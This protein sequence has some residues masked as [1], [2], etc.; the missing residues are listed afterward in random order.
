MREK[1]S[2]VIDVGMTQGEG[3]QPSWSLGGKNESEQTEEADSTGKSKVEQKSGGEQ[4][5][6]INVR[7]TGFYKRY[8]HIEFK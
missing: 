8:Q 7:I 3:E 2:W 5:A 6:S 4:R 1:R